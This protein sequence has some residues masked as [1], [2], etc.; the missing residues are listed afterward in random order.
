MMNDDRRRE[1]ALFRY[2][3]LG[4]L[5]NA[6][7]KRGALRRVLEQKA[8][9]VWLLPDGRSCRLAA[10]TIQ[11]W[12]YSYRARGIDGL[13]PGERKDKGA[14]RS[15]LPEVQALILDMKREDPERSTP[16]ILRELADAGLVRR[17]DVS[18]SAVNRLLRCNGLSGPQM[19]IET[20]ARHRFVRSFCTAACHQADPW[21]P[22]PLSMSPAHRLSLAGH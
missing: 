12:L 19:K 6:E 8:E 5:V 21:S 18:P 7:L 22:P 4:E 17:G 2:A 1:I 10:K 13:L 16:L 14:C 3:V 11:S 9:Q 20:V 15:I